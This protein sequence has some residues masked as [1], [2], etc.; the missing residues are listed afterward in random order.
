MKIPWS[1]VE[2]T[3]NEVN[4][5]SIRESRPSNEGSNY[6]KLT[7]STCGETQRE[8]LV[9]SRL[10]IGYCSLVVK[11]EASHSCFKCNT[12]DHRT[13][14][15]KVESETL[16]EVQ[17]AGP[18]LAWLKKPSHC[19]NCKRRFESPTMESRGWSCPL[20]NAKALM[21][22]GVNIVAPGEKSF[23]RSTTDLL[24]RDKT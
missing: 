10:F 15:C 2:E 19:K 21:L 20:R 22:A 7:I 13:A 16:W 11:K 5:L 1:M 23:L 8:L 4:I 9:R 17:S 6:V 24:G 18:C 14:E 3:R 12:L